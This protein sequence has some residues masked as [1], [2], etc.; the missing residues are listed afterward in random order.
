MPWNLHFAIGM[1]FGLALCAILYFKYKEIP[2]YAPL[3]MTG[4]GIWAIIPSIL[5]F[6]FDI[7]L[8]SNI[9]FF[10]P[11]IRSMFPTGGQYVGFLFSLFLYNIGIVGQIMHVRK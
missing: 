2:L 7:S 11:L 6:V 4:L 5:R 1:G 8:D 9:F 3:I 10:Y